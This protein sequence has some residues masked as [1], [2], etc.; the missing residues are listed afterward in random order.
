M[1]HKQIKEFVKEKLS[2]LKK[3]Y[4]ER[5]KYNKETKKEAV[6][7][8]REEYQRVRIAG[9][10]E[11]AKRDAMNR[12]KGMFTGLQKRFEGASTTADTAGSLFFGTSNKKKKKKDSL[13]FEGLI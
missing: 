8:Y 1:P 4:Q 5:A 11:K 9:A 12:S 13:G 2:N 3:N 6:K 10:R 7:A